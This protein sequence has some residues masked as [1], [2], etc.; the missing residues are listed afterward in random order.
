MKTIS[1][2]RAPVPVGRGRRG[3]HFTSFGHSEHSEESRGLQP[4]RGLMPLS[5]SLAALG[6]TAV[7]T[8]VTFETAAF[9]ADAPTA[10]IRAGADGHLAY[11][12]DAQGNRV[13]DFSAAGYAGGEAIPFVPVKVIVAPDGKHDGALIQ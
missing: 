11:T 8:L 12:A 2:W 3:R 6:M 5:R 7:I 1:R 4:I 9:A 10:T 13:I